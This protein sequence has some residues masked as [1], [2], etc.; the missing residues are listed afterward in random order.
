MVL[1][2][3]KKI[4]KKNYTKIICKIKILH[5]RPYLLRTHEEPSVGCFPH[6]DEEFV[7]FLV[8]PLW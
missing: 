2:K 4:I 8:V 5:H 1:K 6:L 3:Y 7:V